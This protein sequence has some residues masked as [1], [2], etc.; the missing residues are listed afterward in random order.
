M[1]SITEVARSVGF[2]N[3]TGATD[4]GVGATIGAGVVDGVIHTEFVPEDEILTLEAG[5]YMWPDAR[6]GAEVVPGV[7]LNKC[8]L[9]GATGVLWLEFGKSP[10]QTGAN[11]S[12]GDLAWCVLVVVADEGIGN[13][14][15]D[16]DKSTDE[17]NGFGMTVEKSESEGVGERAVDQSNNGSTI[18][19]GALVGSR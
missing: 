8:V 9:A 3:V 11:L 16:T 2:N 1:V 19:R 13:G 7:A 15:A 10:I 17:A 12:G 18:G 6:L 14:R 4:R 5:E